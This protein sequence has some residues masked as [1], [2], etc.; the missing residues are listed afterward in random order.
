[1]IDQTDPCFLNLANQMRSVFGPFLY[2]FCS[3]ATGATHVRILSR[4]L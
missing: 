2:F 1:M 3:M 4:I